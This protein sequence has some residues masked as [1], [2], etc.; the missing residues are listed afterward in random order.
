M[1]MQLNPLYDRSVHFFENYEKGPRELTKPETAEA[2]RLRKE[3]KELESEG[4]SLRKSILKNFEVSMPFGISSGPAY[5]GKFLS[6]YN[7][8]GYGFVTQKTVRDRRWE[9]NPM[10]HNVYLAKGSLD[11]GY[12]VSPEPTEIMANSFGMHSLAP[13]VWAPDLAAFKKENPKA[14]LVISG[15]VTQ[16][17]KR[18]EAISQYVKIGVKAEEIKA[19]AY[20]L[21][22]S[23]PNEMEGHSNELQDDLPFVE[24]VLDE[25]AGKIK[26]PVFIKIG[27]R[28]DLSEFA[29]SV[30]EVLDNRG[31]IVAINAISAVVRNP[32]GSLHFGEKRPKAGISYL[33][34]APQAKDALNQLLKVRERTGYNFKIFSVGG[35]ARPEDVSER[36]KMGADAVES[37]AAAMTYPMLALETRKY[38]LQQK[39]NGKI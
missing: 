14:T 29:T 27:Y 25:V 7:K 17:K 35:V 32:E 22:V 1:P 38:L 37:G 26:I 34:I 9:G 15:V 6:M 19:D 8:L 12:I 23:C 28:K 20:E 33:P 13:E 31:A 5:G 2:E 16:A 30:G 11:E 24:D 39:L 4:V 3:I 18:E 10:P 21:N 36:L